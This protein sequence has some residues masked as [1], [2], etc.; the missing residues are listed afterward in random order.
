MGNVQSLRNKP[1][2]LET[3]VRYLHEFRGA[4][5]LCL[6]ETWFS[7]LDSDPQLPGFTL[8]HCD[9][10]K[11]ATGKKKGGGVCIFVNERWCSKMTLKEQHCCADVELL[12]VALRPCH[13]LFRPS[14]KELSV[15]CVWLY[16]VV[17]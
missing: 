17:S 14:L 15:V 3:C 16:S 11:V 6:T 2:E 10:S 4:S 12:T 13:E 7:E 5:L 1:D 8:M 9:R